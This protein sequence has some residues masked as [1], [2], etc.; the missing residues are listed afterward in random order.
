M[1][2][3][4]FQG[5]PE[6]L[7]HLSQV[8]VDSDDNDSLGSGRRAGRVRSAE[9][10]SPRP[11]S[12]LFAAMHRSS[13]GKKPFHLPKD[14]YTSIRLS[15]N[16]IAP[17]SKRNISKRDSEQSDSGRYSSD[18]NNLDSLNGGGPGGSSLQEAY[19]ITD[20]R[21]TS[22]QDGYL[23][24]HV[25]PTPVLSKSS[26]VDN[27]RLDNP[28]AVQVVMPKPRERVNSS[29]D[30]ID[31]VAIVKAKK[32]PSPVL[33][34]SMREELQRLAQKSPRP[35]TSVSKFWIHNLTFP[36]PVSPKQSASK[37]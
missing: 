2:S 23:V 30:E 22:L 31:A 15:S 20:G 9:Y 26:S 33:V 18:D 37:K 28:T 19:L 5:I 8:S 21:T 14:D 4:V 1:T 17:E 24:Q 11:A 10:P 6:R 16:I 35:D 36:S 32:D 7:K 12:Q 27:P 25:R 13:K 34:T 3:L 29:D